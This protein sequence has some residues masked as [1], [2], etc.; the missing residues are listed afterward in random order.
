M[1]YYRLY[2]KQLFKQ[3]LWK[4]LITYFILYS[5]IILVSY[6]S[7]FDFDDNLFNIIIGNFQS[8]TLLSTLWTL[9]QIAF[10]TYIIYL[11]FTN[12]KSNSFEF[13]ILRESNKN[14]TQKK[15]LL[16]LTATLFFRIIVFLFTYSVFFR[17]IN[18]P[19]YSLALNL[20]IHIVIII[21]VTAITYKLDKLVI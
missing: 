20:C 15:I 6:L 18:F 14:I 7:D 2:F 9:F 8:N 16:L 13:I 4:L 12:D 17:N 3:K 10:H 5:M 11:F 21:T 1:K 19:Y